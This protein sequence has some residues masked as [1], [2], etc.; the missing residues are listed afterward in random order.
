NPLREYA[1]EELARCARDPR[2]R[3]GLKLHF[4][5]S[6]VDYHDEQHVE[7]LRQVFRAANGYRMS[8]VVHMRASISKKMKYG[9]DEARIFLNDILSAAPDVPVQIA[10]LAGAGG[11]DDPLVDEA[12]AVF[13][14]A[15]GNEDSRA[16]QLYFDVTTVA[17]PDT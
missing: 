1:L 14:E 6:V 11:Y 5:N 3:A 10:H 17:L 2:L 7:R 15:I 4:G 9:R 8:I 12:L 16:K 13:V